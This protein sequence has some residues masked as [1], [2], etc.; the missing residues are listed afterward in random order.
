MHLLQRSVVIPAHQIIVDRTARHQKTS[1]AIRM[2][3]RLFPFHRTEYACN[4]IGFGALHC[5]LFGRGP[6]SRERSV[7]KGFG[8]TRLV[9]TI[10]RTIAMADVMTENATPRPGV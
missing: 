8:V 2:A 10:G 5:Q 1:S 4:R 3:G 7:Q 9:I 6:D